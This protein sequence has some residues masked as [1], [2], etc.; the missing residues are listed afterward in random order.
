M[1]WNRKLKIT[2]LHF[3]PVIVID[4]FRLASHITLT[5]QELNEVGQDDKRLDWHNFFA[6]VDPS[7][8]L[9][10]CFLHPHFLSC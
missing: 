9:S 2:I 4:L 10:R 3:C 1:A 8:H 6:S 7:A 5:E